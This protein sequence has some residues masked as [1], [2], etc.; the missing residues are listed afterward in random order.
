[1]ANLNMEDKPILQIN[2]YIRIAVTL[3]T[4]SV[5]LYI[6][7]YFK[8]IAIYMLMGVVL[9]LV[10]RPIY[11]FLEK[12]QVGRFKIPNPLSAILS[13]LSVWVVFIGFFSILVPQL[14]HQ[15][16][17]LSQ[18]DP[19]IV[20]EGLEEPANKTISFLEK[21]GILNFID[22]TQA[23]PIEVIEKQIL[24]EAIPDSTNPEL[25][26]YVAVDTLYVHNLASADS[27]D[28][29]SVKGIIHRAQLEEMLKEQ[30][31]KFFS[32]TKVTNV[33]ESL[34]S[35]LGNLLAA[36]FSSTFIAFF[37]LR[38]QS[39]FYKIVLASVPEK[40]EKQTTMILQDSRRLLSRYFI[41]LG[42]QLTL[43]MTCVTI[44]LLI[45]GFDFQ[46]AITIGFLCGF[47]NII[48]Y[49][50]PLL[51]GAVGLMLGVTNYIEL[52]F[53]TQIVP[54][55][56]KMIIVFSITQFLDNVL[57][58]PLIFSNSVNAHPL[59]IFIVIIIAGSLAGIP[60]MIFAVP[61]Y[62]FLRI[63][64]RQF[65]MNFKIVRTLTKNM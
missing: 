1:M 13:L 4:L 40:Y 33:F 46:I 53:A 26:K 31:V 45:I 25:F 36:I 16:S 35:L 62:T 7:W 39:L 57:F 54:L 50:G 51:G 29:T 6:L 63:I 10:A 22:T 60:G 14:I 12:I 42:I 34:F 8:T 21:Y 19:E 61:G 48:P 55:M 44:G 23:V 2:R 15:G 58:Q 47:F 28:T 27:N 41:G 65:F 43:I 9:S 49:L 30:L 24:V 3:I 59:E 52:D 5:V 18:L 20:L 32:F 38:D 11:K 17:K 56:G 64:A 37:F